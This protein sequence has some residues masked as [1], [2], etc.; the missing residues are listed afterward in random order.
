MI[1]LLTLASAS[2]A[3]AA[4]VSMT[5]SPDGFFFLSCVIQLQQ[6]NSDTE[7]RI[8]ESTR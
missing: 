1:K 3:A 2:T 8:D 7:T 4:V 6:V 5:T